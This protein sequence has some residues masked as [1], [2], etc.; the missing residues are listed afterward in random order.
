[1]KKILFLIII[2]VLHSGLVLTQ[3]IK[4]DS[5]TEVGTLGG[6]LSISP[7]GAASY[8]IPINLPEGRGGVMP[9]LSF[10]YYSQ[11]GNGLM[12]IRWMLGGLSIISRTATNIYNDGFIDGV[13]FAENDKFDIDGQRLIPVNELLNEYRTEAETFTK[14]IAHGADVYNPEW[15]EVFTKDGKIVEYGKVDNN[16][17]NSQFV[18][19]GKSSTLIWQIN[20]MKDRQG[21]YIDFYYSGDNEPGKIVKIRYTGN[22]RNNSEPFYDIDF[23]YDERDDKAK[24]FISGGYVECKSLMK[25][26]TISYNTSVVQSYTINYSFE[27]L[28][29][30]IETIT[31]SEANGNSLRP[32]RFEYGMNSNDFDLNVTNI[33][34]PS[35]K[36]VD[37]SMGDFNGDG[38]T[39]ILC[40]YYTINNG[41]HN[42]ENWK[43]FY[44]EGDGS[45]FTESESINHEF[46]FLYFIP[47]DFNGDGIQDLVK[48][49]TSSFDFL[50][51]DGDSFIEKASKPYNG[52][53]IETTYSGNI[54]DQ[55]S[56]VLFGSPL[57]TKT[58]TTNKGL[59]NNDMNG[60]G[61]DEILLVNYDLGNGMAMMNAYELDGTEVKDLFYRDVNNNGTNF[62][63]GYIFPYDINESIPIRSGDFTGD[64]KTNLIVNSETNR[65]IILELDVLAN[66]PY[67]VLVE[68][69]DIGYEYPTQNTTLNSV[70]DFN[71]DGISDLFSNRTALFFDGKNGWITGGSIPPVP[72]PPHFYNYRDYSFAFSDFNG[73]GKTDVLRIYQE[74]YFDVHTM[75]E[76][77][78]IDS[79]WE[80]F[81]S[82]GTTFASESFTPQSQTPTD[83][84][85]H[86]VQFMDANGDGKSECFMGGKESGHAEIMFFHKDEQVYNIQKITNGLAHETKIHYESL[87][88]TDNYTKGADSH[89]P[90]VDV[91]YPIFVVTKTEE[92]NAIGGFF[93]KEYYYES[94]RMHLLGKGSLGF[95]RLICTDNQANV[96]T[97]TENGLIHDNDMYYYVFPERIVQH[98]L[99]FNGEV[100]LEE[101]VIE[102]KN[103]V[104]IKTTLSGNNYVYY[105]VTTKSTEQ[106]WDNESNNTFV[107]MKSTIQPIDEVDVWGNSK[108]SSIIVS[109]EESGT[110]YSTTNYRT[111]FFNDSD[112]WILG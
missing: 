87:S 11:S 62:E 92:D 14:V 104:S 91:Q 105:P 23:S 77:E 86:G 19:A 34:V 51:K 93:K 50:I 60:N 42:N 5:S 65:C 44:S 4:L 70:G 107:K 73:D 37:Y 100:N 43:V 22:I 17:S 90:L 33:V 27:D 41:V 28:Y 74:Y 29:P 98:P 99:M 112:N 75:T 2:C 39:D 106:Y 7:T 52:G 57:P 97:I 109:G 16:N 32:S 54:W 103:T 56:N 36:K 76:E 12:G 72:T 63:P 45:N 111:E 68:I 102:V 30:K 58:T 1:M 3:E 47:G 40:S 13:D 8:T 89:Y 82:N 84:Y 38:I 67:P 85:R 10:N 46:D 48:V 78:F 83:L 110:M 66:A 108:S 31:T 81:Y 21:N 80:I 53:I 18:P 88:T 24:L 94:L 69:N 95:Q 20:R 71:G 6:N 101:K 25:K 59:Q 55:F 9:N 64:G 15:F 49:S 79:H 26:V 35:E 96:Q 61:I